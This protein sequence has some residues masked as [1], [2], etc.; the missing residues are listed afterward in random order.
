MKGGVAYRRVRRSGA[1]GNLFFIRTAAVTAGD[2]VVIGAAL[3]VAAEIKSRPDAAAERT[4][5]FKD[6]PLF[7]RLHRFNSFDHHPGNNDDPHLQAALQAGDFKVLF[8]GVS[9]H[10][11]DFEL[12]LAAGGTRDL[13]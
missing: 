1:R 10:V 5:G 11:R 7:R 2:H 13:I 4:L 9:F 3:Q 12:G 6:L 8:I